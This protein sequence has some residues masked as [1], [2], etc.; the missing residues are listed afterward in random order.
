[1]DG[2]LSLTFKPEDL[3]CSFFHYVSREL[4][5]CA[6]IRPVLNLANP[7]YRRKSDILYLLSFHLGLVYLGVI[8]FRRSFL[9][10]FGSCLL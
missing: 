1:M 2:V 4:L 6:V 5:A 8:Y 10:E 7:R 9:S 3:Q